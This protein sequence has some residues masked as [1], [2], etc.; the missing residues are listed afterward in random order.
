[1]RQLPGTVATSPCSR[2]PVVAASPCPGTSTRDRHCPLVA[3]QEGDRPWRVVEHGHRCTGR[4][5]FNN[6]GLLALPACVVIR[7]HSSPFVVIR[8][9]PSSFV[10]IRRLLLRVPDA[11]VVLLRAVSRHRRIIRR[12]RFDRLSS[13]SAVR[14]KQEH[15]S[16]RDRCKGP[17]TRASASPLWMA[18]RDTPS[19][20]LI[21]IVFNITSREPW[22]VR[23]RERCR[24]SPRVRLTLCRRNPDGDFA[25][26]V[27]SIDDNPV[28]H[29]LVVDP[30]ARS[31]RRSV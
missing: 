6:R 11:L 22:N 14:T 23:R 27:D 10:V 15:S 29:G 25:R 26:H 9:H 17:T 8:R 30:E 19:V 24:R 4:Q 18:Q 12:R 1:M 28:E 3:A 5:R 16:G 2:T 20:S 31:G 13:T 21:R 7:R